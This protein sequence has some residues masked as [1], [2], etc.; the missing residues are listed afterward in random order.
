[1]VARISFFVVGNGDMTLIELESGRKILSDVNIRSAADDPDDDTPDVAKELRDRLSRDAEGRLYVDALLLS[2]PDQDH[3]RGLPR[4]FH[5]GPPGDWSKAAD[6]I[7]VRELWSSPM[8]FRRASS[9]HVLCDEAKAFNSEA[10]RRVARFR[11][12]GD[13]IGDGDRILI[14]GKD[15]NG[16]TDDLTPI[17]VKVDQTFSRVN[18]QYDHSMTTRLLAPGP[19]NDDQDEEEL[20]SKNHS[21]TILRFSLLGG[22]KPDA[23]RFLTGGDAEVAIW[24]RLWD[25]HASNADWL[26]YDILLAPHHCSWHSLSYDSWSDFGEE[27]EVNTK[28]RKALSQTRKGAV[29]VASSN[30]I[31]DDDND[32]PCI[33]AKREYVAIAKDA[34]G[35]FKCV[36]EYP[37]AKKLET[38]EFEIGADGPRLKSK[39]MKAAAI[40]GAGSVGSQPLGHG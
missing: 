4:H 15:E 10:R 22:G 13:G 3:C 31:K 23:G 26:S 7:F 34:G 29:I 32:P 2:H 6:K 14:L 17:L 9:Q 1:M 20:R 30:P 18:G 40:I 19:K 16:K 11:E 33:R 8:V 12:A 28:A 37:S 24:E 36:G 5:L 21:S 39:P 35:S 25:R 38:T 27:A